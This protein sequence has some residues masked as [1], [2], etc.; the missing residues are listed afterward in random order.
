MKIQQV[1]VIW[2]LLAVF[3]NGEDLVIRNITTS[4]IVDRAVVIK[5]PWNAVLIEKR[6][7][8]FYALEKGKHKLFRLTVGMNP[9]AV[10]RALFH[11]NDVATFDRTIQEIKLGLEQSLPIAQIWG[12]GDS[13]VMHFRTQDGF[14]SAQ[15]GL[16][17]PTHV[18]TP[19]GTKFRILHFNV[20][21][22]SK[23]YQLSVFLKS[24][25]VLSLVD[26][27]AVLND[28]RRRHSRA[29]SKGQ[30]TVI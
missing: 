17:D 20:A 13:A 9:I 25:N 3:A 29:T 22:N 12:I 6:F 2:I 24:M 4:E 14:T 11:G 27:V 30:L 7:R 23:N 1:K 28:L 8:D 15:I 19:N 26:S 5:E 21:G 18:S 16:L 10:K